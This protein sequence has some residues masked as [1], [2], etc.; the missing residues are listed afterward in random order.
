MRVLLS[1]IGS[2]GDVQPLVALAVALRALGSEVGLCVPPDFREWIEGLGFP[3]TP[4]GPTL[5]ATGKAIP[6]STPPT[7]E[8][9]RLMIEGTVTAQFDTIAAAAEGCDAIVGATTLQIAGPS[10]AERLGIPY[11]FA[12]YCP[13]VIPSAHHAPPVLTMLGDKPA[14]ASNDY[15]PV[16][17]QD[18]QRWNFMWGAA[19]NARRAT[20]GLPAVDDV[21]QHVLTRRPWLAADATLAPWPSDEA[22]AVFQTGAWLL[23]DEQCLPPEL[24]SFLDAGDPPVYFGFGSIR[25]PQGIS[26]VMIDSARALGRG[27][28]VSRGWAD[29]ALL[30]A[31]PDCLSIGD[32]NHSTLFKRVAAVVHHGGAGTTTA[33]TRAGAPQVVIPQH[34]DQ[35]YFAQRVSELG[36]GVAHSL[37]PPSAESLSRALA[38]AL[39]PETAN[40]AKAIAGSIRT[41]GATVAAQALTDG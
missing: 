19:L 35:F 32:V 13:A 33:A 26:R 41:D 24:E 10:V 3:V 37:E 28:I 34:Y 30:D 9:R 25:A 40:R 7:P 14:A 15:R 39:R 16:W 21:L 36:I 5:R 6:S 18:A 1:T 4:I 22:G 31:Q 23:A 20:L 2:R 17:A 12:A 27:V 29:L 38:D 11:V 8:Q